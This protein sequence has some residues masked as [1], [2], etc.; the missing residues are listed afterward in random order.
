MTVQNPS[1]RAENGIVTAK[2]NHSHHEEIL[3]DGPK[4]KLKNPM[5]KNVCIALNEVRQMH[6]IQ[7]QT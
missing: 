2:Y 1:T 5:L 7:A 3:P 4:S 6:H